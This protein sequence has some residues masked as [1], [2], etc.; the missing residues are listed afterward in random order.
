MAVDKRNGVSDAVFLL[1]VSSSLFAILGLDV[2]T[3]GVV[4]GSVVDCRALS[5]GVGV[6]GDILCLLAVVEFLV[7]S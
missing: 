5:W 4:V 1:A 3:P 7:I 2:S 6:D